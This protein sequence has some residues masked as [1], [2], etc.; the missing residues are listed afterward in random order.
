M[1]LPDPIATLA[2]CV[3]SAWFAGA[4]MSILLAHEMGHWWVARRHGF[5]L[6]LPYFIP[7]PVA[8]GTLGA[9]IRLDSPPR[10]RTG[11]LEMA[12][13][14]P[15]AGAVV[16]FLAIALGLPGTE[17]GVSSVPAPCNTA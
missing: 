10:S 14:G 12:A 11:L 7:L 13:A 5:S 3:C 8:F 1:R 9:V 2:C 15:L 17:T 4:L 6:S 16:A